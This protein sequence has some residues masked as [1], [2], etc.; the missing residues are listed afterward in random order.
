[1]YAAPKNEAVCQLKWV[2]PT[3][4]FNTLVKSRNPASCTMTNRTVSKAAHSNRYSGEAMLPRASRLV[5]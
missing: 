4:P 2:D 5:R 3:V 1:M